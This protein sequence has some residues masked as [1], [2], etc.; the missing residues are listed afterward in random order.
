[1]NLENFTR[2]KPNKSIIDKTIIEK[3]QKTTRYDLRT[4]SIQ[5]NI[6]LIQRLFFGLGII[7][8]KG[9]QTINS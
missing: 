9:F 1:M 8:K 3:Q 2:L 6:F 7:P 4:Q 5:L